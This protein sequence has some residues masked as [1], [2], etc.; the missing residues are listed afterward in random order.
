MN[1]TADLRAITARI[2]KA[3]LRAMSRTADDAVLKD[4]VMIARADG[5]LSDE[6]TEFYIAAW[7]L[8]NA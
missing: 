8:K 1:H 2:I 3:A 4:C 6:E 7:G 5:H